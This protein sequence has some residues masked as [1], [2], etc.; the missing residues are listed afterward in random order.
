MLRRERHTPTV[1]SRSM[2]C[3]GSRAVPPHRSCRPASRQARH[4]VETEH[5]GHDHR[6][7]RPRV[8]AWL[9]LHA[10]EPSMDANGHAVRHQRL[11]HKISRQPMLGAPDKHKHMEA[12]TLS[13]TTPKPCLKS[14]ARNLVEGCPKETCSFRGLRLPCDVMST[15]NVH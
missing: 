14:C 8:L 3:F 10:Q 2:V 12:D 5:T 4:S 15:Q 7:C 9:E 11:G 6:G 13:Q 1:G